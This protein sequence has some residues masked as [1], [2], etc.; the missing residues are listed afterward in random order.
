MLNDIHSGFLSIQLGQEREVQLL[1]NVVILSAAGLQGGGKG[2]QADNKGVRQC[3][4]M[5]EPRAGR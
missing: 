2:R 1:S 5:C 3:L 4:C